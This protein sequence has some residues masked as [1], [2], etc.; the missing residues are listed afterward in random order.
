VVTASPHNVYYETA[1]EYNQVVSEFLAEHALM[2]SMER[3]D[4]QLA[5]P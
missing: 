3:A 4:G 1:T 2:P 5:V